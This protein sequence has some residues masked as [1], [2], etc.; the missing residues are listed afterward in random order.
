[1]FGR[2]CSSTASQCQNRSSQSPA[3]PRM[4]VLAV[5]EYFFPDLSGGTPTILSELFRYL[6]SAHPD[7]D[8]CILT[9]NHLYRNQSRPVEL[10]RR[11]V[12]A[13]VHINRLVTARSNR[14]GVHARAVA[15]LTFSAKVLFW[16]IGHHTYD[17]VVVVTNPPSAPPIVALWSRFSRT[18]FVYLVHD[19]YP[20]LAV[21]VGRL[22][23][24]GL[25]ARLAHRVQKATV[26]SAAVV[27]V[28]GRCMKE[29]LES[30][31]SADPEKIRVSPNWA[32]AGSWQPDDNEG[33]PGKASVGFRIAYAGNMGEQLDVD[34]LIGCAK[35]LQD[36]RSPIEFVLVGDGARKSDL[37]HGI[38][39]LHLENMRVLPRV[40]QKEV[41]AILAGADAVLVPLASSLKG[42][43]TPSKLYSSMAS[44]R[45]IV[46]LV[47]EGSEAALVVAEEACGL[48]VSESDP[49][50]LANA[51]KQLAEDTAL[52]VE[53]GERGR[54]AV[55]AKYRLEVI[56]EEFY[57]LLE[58][59]ARKHA[60]PRQGRP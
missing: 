51:V 44:G 34:L 56:G 5:S 19:L 21:A 41:P 6:K 45:P 8:V 60:R 27:V 54:Q 20:D 4:R 9:S 59:I 11:E 23:E 28:L 13:G 43:G 32:P 25:T 46:A 31:Y 12:W 22:G 16:L 36:E 18:P 33:R 2:S 37:I 1:M 38:R 10:P 48:V 24:K 7:M 14:R 29:V 39:S 35:T 40:T 52:C 47:P 15:G 3:T 55:G 26:R 57:M 30:R 17:V 42:M 50:R 53:M 58:Q 49:V